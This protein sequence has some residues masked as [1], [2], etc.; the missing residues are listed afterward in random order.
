VLELRLELGSALEFALVKL[1]ELGV[2][3]AVGE[4][5]TLLMGRMKLERMADRR[6]F[7]YKDRIQKLL[8][9][10]APVS[11]SIL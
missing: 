11:G 2:L 3:A 10:L 9:F 1:G 7:D 6:A 4:E 8:A 5:T